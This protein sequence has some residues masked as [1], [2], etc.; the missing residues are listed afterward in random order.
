[1]LVFCPVQRLCT[2]ALC[3]HK[4]EGRSLTHPVFREVKTELLKKPQTRQDHFE[5]EASQIA[6]L[7]RL[8]QP[9]SVASSPLPPIGMGLGELAPEQLSDQV[10]SGTHRWLPICRP[11]REAVG[12]R[13]G[14]ESLG[15]RCHSPWSSCCALNGFKACL[16]AA[17]EAKVFPPNQCSVQVKS[18]SH[19]TP[20][21]SEPLASN[22]KTRQG[23]Q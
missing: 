8:H 15:T 13:G 23:R 14:R 20:N 16:T 7:L 3:F 18:H 17:S 22:A 5:A 9:L 6:A 19:W 10:S 1:M 21:L 11:S 12:G 4:P 2:L